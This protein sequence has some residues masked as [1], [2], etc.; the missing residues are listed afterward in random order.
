MSSLW[1]RPKALVLRLWRTDAP[2]TGTGLFMLV[3]L[4]AFGAGLWLDPR[5][6]LGAPVWLKPAKFAAS[7]AVYTFTLAWLF[8]YLPAQRRTRRV[9]SWATAAAMLIEIAIIGGQAARGTTSHFNVSTPLNATLWTGMGLA[10]VTQT[11]TSIA[12]AVA[13]FRQPFADRALG[14]ALRLGMAIT[15]AGAFLGGTMTRPDDAQLADM[16]AG[17][18]SVAGAHTVGAPDGGPGVAI[19][20]WSRD[21]G[22]LRVAHFLGLHALQALPLLAVALRRT[23]VAPSRQVRLIA[24]AAGSYTALVAIVLW[25]ALRG[26][27]IVAPDLATL[28]ALLIWLALTALLAWRSVASRRLSRA[29]A[30][31]TA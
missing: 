4:A 22:D 9:V 28:G 21:H 16:R 19:T 12:V 13:L 3:L 2:L 11:V 26:Q 6:V 10:I 31:T 1:T 30:P 14:W 15:I 7:I 8:G 17:R 27:S 23:R 25:Q 24:T 20:G 18:P 5:T 29:T